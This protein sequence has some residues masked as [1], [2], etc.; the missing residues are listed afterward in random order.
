MCTYTQQCIP[1]RASVSRK[2]CS[3]NV[4]TIAVFGTSLNQ[5]IY[6]TIS[7][8]LCFINPSVGKNNTTSPLRTTL[9]ARAACDCECDY[10]HTHMRTKSNI[11]GRGVGGG[12][13]TTKSESLPI[14][15]VHGPFLS[16]ITLKFEQPS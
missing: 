9:F 1:L 10:V 12:T 8:L 7:V 5:E 11:V 6:D 15:S 2:R 13:S 14:S 16:F 4:Y 3:L